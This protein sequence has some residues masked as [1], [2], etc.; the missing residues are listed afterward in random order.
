MNASLLKICLTVALLTPGVFAADPS[1]N[2]KAAAT[3][4]DSRMTWWTTWPVSARDH[5]TF[6]VSCHTVLPYAMARPAL[7]KTLAE[8]S[9]S[10]P[11]HKLLDNVTKRVRMWHDLEPFYPDACAWCP[12]DGGIARHGIY[13]ERHGSRQLRCLRCYCHEPRYATGIQEHVG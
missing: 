4:L 5:G 2:G 1:Y 9:P 7:R 10:A 11:E 13:S 12:Q 8:T 3:Y 6:C